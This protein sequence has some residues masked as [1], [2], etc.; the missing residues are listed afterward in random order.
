MTIATLDAKLSD[1][2]ESYVVKGS[3]LYVE[4][5]INYDKYERDGET[6]YF[7]KIK[8]FSLQMLDS[9]KKSNDDDSFA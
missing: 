4:G 1:V 9:K 6:K 8:A 2:V 3:K 5:E 7:T